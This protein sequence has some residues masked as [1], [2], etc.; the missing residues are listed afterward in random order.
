MDLH[1]GVQQ[2]DAQLSSFL[3]CKQVVQQ[4][5]VWL[6]VKWLLSFFYC[7]FPLCFRNMKNPLALQ[8]YCYNFH[9]CQHHRLYDDGKCT[10]A[11]AKTM[12]WRRQR[13]SVYQSRRHQFITTAD[14]H[15]VDY[16][17]TMWTKR[18][19]SPF[20]SLSSL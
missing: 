9:L 12:C 20:P 15:I 17:C 4:N 3:K 10:A 2:A 14:R 13:M 16:I 18:V 6:C 11:V 7:F 1:C 19:A 8:V 5:Y